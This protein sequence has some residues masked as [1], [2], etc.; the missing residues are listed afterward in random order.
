MS[1]QVKIEFKNYDTALTSLNLA[2]SVLEVLSEV[3]HEHGKHLSETTY[4]VQLMIEEAIS[5]LER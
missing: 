2:R 3:V 4:A 5:E 1:N